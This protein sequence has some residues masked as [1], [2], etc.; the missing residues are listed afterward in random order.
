MERTGLDENDLALKLSRGKI[1]DEYVTDFF[2]EFQLVNFIEDIESFNDS[3]KQLEKILM[4]L[5][6]KNMKLEVLIDELNHVFKNFEDDHNINDKDNIDNINDKNNINDRDIKYLKNTLSSWLYNIQ[7]LENIEQNRK[8]VES[9]IRL[10]IQ[11]VLDAITKYQNKKIKEIDPIVEII[12][13]Y[14]TIPYGNIKNQVFLSHAFSDRLYTLGLFLYF[15]DQNIY[16]YV[17]WMHQPKNSKTKTLKKNLIQ[18]IQNSHQLLFL[19]TLNS[20]LYLQGGSRQLRQWCAWEI[21]TFDYK[22]NGADGSR[23]FIDRYRPSKQGQSRSRLIQDFK[24]LREIK[25]GK[26]Y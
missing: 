18:E 22:T 6:K 14:Y 11:K 15:Y 8:E 17:D 10:S 20:E 4:L 12:N 7:G 1:L 25:N 16:L 3:V 9:S 2:K 21:G 13:R 5:D 24:P 19:R 26:L 23:F